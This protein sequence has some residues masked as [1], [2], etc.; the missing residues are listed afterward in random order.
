MGDQGH[1]GGSG[2]AASTKGLAVV[3][4]VLLAVA[5][6]RQDPGPPK[7]EL[8]TT[9]AVRAGAPMRASRPVSLSIPS[10]GI[11]APIENL[12]TDD[13]QR[14]QTPSDPQAAGWYRGSSTPG[15]AGAAVIAGHVTWSQQ[16]A[17]FFRLGRLSPGQR[18]R[19]KRADGG[20]AVFVITEIEEYAKADF[21]TSRVYRPGIRPALRLITCGGRFDAARDTYTKN[22][23]AYGT[24]VAA[25][26]GERHS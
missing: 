23:V 21:P 20:T 11:D 9:L 7:P 13:D 4:V 10:L 17:V 19:V 22:V 26:T 6:L 18:V 15:A 16:P 14:L 3:G 8:G 2:L 1:R 25:R 5:V 12:G 24:L